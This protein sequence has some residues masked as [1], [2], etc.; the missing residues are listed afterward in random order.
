MAL[1]DTLYIPPDYLHNNVKKTDN[2]KPLSVHDIN[3]MNLIKCNCLT[4]F[5]LVISLWRMALLMMYSGP[6]Y[7]FGG[8]IGADQFRTGVV[9]VF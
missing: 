3:L 5:L 6:R 7:I 2:S 9:F 4:Q 8:L 1:F